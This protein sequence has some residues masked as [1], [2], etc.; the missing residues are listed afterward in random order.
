MYNLVSPYFPGSNRC[1]LD[2]QVW[3]CFLPCHSGMATPSVPAENL[4]IDWEVALGS[5]SLVYFVYCLFCL[6]FWG[7]EK[8]N[9]PFWPQKNAKECKMH[10]CRFPQLWTSAAAFSI[11]RLVWPCSI[12]VPVYNVGAHSPTRSSWHWRGK[13]CVSSK[14]QAWKK[15]HVCQKK[16]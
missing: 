6:F 14:F 10:L 12:Y 5:W 4:E 13:R 15:T 11:F 1:I 16:Y 2:R 7:S 9:I 3:C 8:L